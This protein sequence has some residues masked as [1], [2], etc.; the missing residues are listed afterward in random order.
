MLDMFSGFQKDYCF[1]SFKCLS[2]E[3]FVVIISVALEFLMH[4]KCF[5]RHLI[6]RPVW[7]FQEMVQEIILNMFSLH[8]AWFLFWFI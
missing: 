6:Q 4:L 7:Q 2:Y 1:P 3:E 5:N 8:D